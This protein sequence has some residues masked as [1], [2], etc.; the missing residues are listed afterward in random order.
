MQQQIQKEMP[1]V[2]QLGMLPYCIPGTILS[3]REI[4]YQ[5]LDYFLFNGKIPTRNYGLTAKFYRLSSVFVFSNH[6]SSDKKLYFRRTG[7]AA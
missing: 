4:M 7:R 6:F 1:T 5:K 2:S 3:L